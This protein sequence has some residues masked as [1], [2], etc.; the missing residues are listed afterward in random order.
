MKFVLTYTVRDGGS[1][2][3][4]ETEAKRGLQLL[5]KFEPSV[6]ISEWVDRVDGNGGFAILESDD[7]PA[8]LKD[9]AIWAPFFEFGLYPVVDIGESTARQ[10]EAVDFRDS[11]L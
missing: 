6:Q 5:P 10:Q 4:R 1:A 7:A 9:I 3:E 8:M 11:I 2:E